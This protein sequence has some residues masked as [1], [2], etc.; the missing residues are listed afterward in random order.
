MFTAEF[1]IPQLLKYGKTWKASTNFWLN[2]TC[3]KSNFWHFYLLS[4]L[5]SLYNL[6]EVRNLLTL[7]VLIHSIR[8]LYECCYVTN[9]GQSKIHLSHYLVGI[10]F[11]TTLNVGI[12]LYHDETQYPLLSMILF[13]LSTLDQTANHDY[14]SKLKKY[15]QPS[16]GLFKYV[17]SA[18]YF[19]EILI[20]FSFMLM[21]RGS[22]V[23][24]LHCIAW[25][26]VN[27]GTSS[28]ETGNWYVENFGYRSRWFLIPFVF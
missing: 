16:Y 21:N 17:C 25:I 24:L 11:Y 7:C 9:W 12:F 14:L 15:S 3:A 26:L 13:L 2:L 27:L 8:R 10:W 18:H 4:T 19:D 6:L 20:Y 5:L 28:F 22:R 1:Y 23:L